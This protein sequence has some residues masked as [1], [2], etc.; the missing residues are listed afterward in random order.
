MCDICA[1]TGV[2]QYVPLLK[3]IINGNLVIYY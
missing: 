1:R 2:Y 3:E